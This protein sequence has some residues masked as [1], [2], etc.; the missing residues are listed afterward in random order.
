VCEAERDLLS[1]YVRLVV[2]VVVVVVVVRRS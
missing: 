1:A 2:V